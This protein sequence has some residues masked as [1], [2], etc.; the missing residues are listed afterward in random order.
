[1]KNKFN[2]DSFWT[3][4]SKEA[5]DYTN[6]LP[7]NRRML[8]KIALL[9]GKG[10][11]ILD[12]GCGT[13]NLIIKLIKNNKVTGLDL[14]DSMLSIAA[15]KTKQ[16]DFVTLKQGDVTKLPFCDNIFDVVTSVN[17]IY[18]LNNPQSAIKEA[19]RVLKDNGL[20]IV[21]SPLKGV[22]LTKKFIKKVKKDCR[23]GNVDPKKLSKIK[24]YNEVIF[25]KRGFKFTPNFQEI[26][27]LLMSY[28][29][30]ILHKE[31]VNYDTNF[32]ICARKIEDNFKG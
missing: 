12:A 4:F 23:E 32:L 6:L 19:R 26:S 28:G 22:S 7:E 14:N 16:Y 20:L 13:G 3:E 29:F 24:K 17:V 2:W 11:N 18:N 15:K 31:K 27:K 30:E 25:K 5:Y 8:N 21:A 10:N 1:M 9:A